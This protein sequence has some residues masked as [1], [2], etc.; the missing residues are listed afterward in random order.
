V[1]GFE[2]GGVRVDNQR[3]KL[4]INDYNILT[5]KLGKVPIV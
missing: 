4:Q 5:L 1:K 2:G 3:L